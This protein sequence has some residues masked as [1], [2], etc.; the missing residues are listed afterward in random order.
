MFV[1]VVALVLILP[2]LLKM[3]KIRAPLKYFSS[4]FCP[5]AHRATIALEHHR[6]PYDWEEA[7]GWQKHAPTGTEDFKGLLICSNRKILG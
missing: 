2:S 3:A 7:L 6:V 1:V 5:F 4:W